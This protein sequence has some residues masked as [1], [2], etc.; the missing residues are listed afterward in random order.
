MSDMLS[1]SCLQLG[2]PSSQERQA[3]AYRAVVVL[4]L[5]AECSL[6]T[7]ERD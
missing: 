2:R 3:K 7:H 1:L 5:L 6:L 4:T